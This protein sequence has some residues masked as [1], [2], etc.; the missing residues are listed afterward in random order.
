MKKLNAKLSIPKLKQ[1]HNYQ[2]P[3]NVRRDSDTDPTTAS[4]ATVTN[5]LVGGW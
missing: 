4:L 1:V 3:K 5:I 2:Q